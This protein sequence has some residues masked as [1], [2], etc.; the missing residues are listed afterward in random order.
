MIFQEFAR[1]RIFYVVEHR[2]NKLSTLFILIIDRVNNLNVQALEAKTL[3]KDETRLIRLIWH[4][5][6]DVLAV[7]QATRS[8][9]VLRESVKFVS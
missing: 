6:I 4:V 3:I 8:R 7:G 1:K 5:E 9:I 2:L